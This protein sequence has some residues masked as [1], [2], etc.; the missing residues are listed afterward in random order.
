MLRQANRTANR[1]I[2]SAGIGQHS[3]N[4]HATPWM[5]ERNP[6]VSAKGCSAA[7]GMARIT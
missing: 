5:I 4:R 3:V 2:N 1:G 6:L 7:M